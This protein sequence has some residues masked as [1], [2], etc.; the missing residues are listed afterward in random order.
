MSYDYSKI[1]IGYYDKILRGPL[2]LRR[3][4][5]QHKFDSVRRLLDGY[6]KATLLDVGCF[7]GSFLSE[8]PESMF[9][10]Q[11]GVDILPEQIDYANNHY[12][13]EFRSFQNIKSL[14]DLN[15][16]DNHFDVITLIEVL[17]HLPNPEIVTI[18]EAAL[19][20]LKNDG[21]LIITTP[22][23]FSIWP[24]L[25]VLIDRFSDIQYEDQH[26]IHFKYYSIISQLEAI[27]PQFSQQFQVELLTTSHFLS[28]FVSPISYS[29]ALKLSNSINP[30]HWRFPLGA[31]ILLKVK[32]RV[33]AIAKAAS[34]GSES[35]S[36]RVRMTS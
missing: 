32:K 21:E 12:K 9:C 33:N 7:G 10:Q 11:V 3:F 13:N 2:S 23:Y 31:I 35:F 29:L 6:E 8:I 22:N 5:H 20:L 14:S 28:P 15:Q 27:Y 34:E 30:K 16:W 4:W 17:E 1:P 36:G 24:V 25:E 18:F 26:L 19:K